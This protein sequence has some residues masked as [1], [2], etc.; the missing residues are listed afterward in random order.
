MIP[1][2]TRLQVASASGRSRSKMLGAGMLQS[3]QSAA[4]RHGLSFFCRTGRLAGAPC[5][6]SGQTMGWPSQRATR[7]MRLRM[8]GAP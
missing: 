5:V 8:V 4:V 3:M 6:G 2:A 7:N 1:F